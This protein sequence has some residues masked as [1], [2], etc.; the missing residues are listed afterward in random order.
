MNES[1]R[2]LYL[3]LLRYVKPYWKRF[4]LSILGMALL[5]AM[6]PALPAL[7]KPL[8]DGSFI[9]EPVGNIGLI[10]LLL[11]L[12]FLVRGILMFV[13]QI[14][15][16]WVSQRVVMD[17]R[18]DIFNKLLTL[19]TAFYDDNS[20]G[21][22]ISKITYDTV[23]VRQ[24]ITRVFAVL[25]KDSLAIIGLVAYMIYLNWKLSLIV[26]LLVPMIGLIVSIVS[27]RMR[28]MSRLVQESMGDITHVAQEVIE[29]QKAVKIYS[30]Q[31]YEKKRFT[32][33]INKTRQYNMKI[34]VASAANSPIIQFIMSFGLAT[35][36]YYS[37]FLAHKGLMTAGE[38]VAYFTA[39]MMLLAPI[40]R[41]AKANEPLQNGLAAAT[42]LFG[43][44][45]ETTEIDHGTITIGRAK[46]ALRFDQVSM[47]YQN[48]EKSTLSNVSIEIASGETVAL[49]GTSGSGKSTFANLIPRFYSP[50]NGSIFL[51]NQD[52]ET[53]TLD[54]LRMNIALVSQEI[55]LFN[56]TIKNNIAYGALRDVSNEE[57]TT[58]AAS[59][60]ALEFIE[61]SPEGM[62]TLI[63]EKGARLSGGQR[64]RLSIARAL[65]KD[66][67]VLILDEAT[68]A[69]DTA[70]E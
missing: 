47:T 45:D 65:L 53:I 62:D 60:H 5:G 31:G 16:N 32:R 69:L 57:I 22:L 2:K 8:L 13:S 66:A 7:L 41:L 15:S 37:T 58:A 39:M 34:A 48:A 55:M 49:V 21:S 30:G 19:P 67:P 14:L 11:V 17:L 68:S 24:S 29:S 20:S 33:A 3:R 40:R 27:K 63:G 52:I 28:T 6:E 56:D 9:D 61:K 42:S 44:I 64:Q 26:F 70:S 51:D 50:E 12:L 36:I 43:L 10:P 4:A 54:S 23:Q 59:A 18:T 38:F 25:V 46:G 35:V 1:D